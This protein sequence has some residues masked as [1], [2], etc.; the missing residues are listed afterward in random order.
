MNV[1]PGRALRQGTVVFEATGTVSVA[2]QTVRGTGDKNWDK[3]TP[4]GP[5]RYEIKVYRSDKGWLM[6]EWTER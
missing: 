3:A 5:I 2:P 6:G 1:T 4:G